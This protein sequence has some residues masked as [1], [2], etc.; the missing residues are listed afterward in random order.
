MSPRTFLVKVINAYDLEL[1]TGHSSFYLD[2]A[3]L[4]LFVIEDQI[5]EPNKTTLVDFGVS[6]QCRSYNH[7]FWEWFKNKSVYQYHS[8]LLMPRSSIYKT[9]LIMQNSIGLIDAGYLGNIKMP[10]H[11]ISNRP[12]LIKRG[13]RYAQL[14]NGDLSTVKLEIVGNHRKTSRSTRG[15]G[16]TS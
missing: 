1:Y 4:D 9:P 6:C 15:F 13:E 8:Y 5:L 7:K 16:S 14:V 10:M 3:G 2:D 11:N 12:Y